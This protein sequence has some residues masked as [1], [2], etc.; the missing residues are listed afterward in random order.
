MKELLLI[1]LKNHDELD[2]DDMRFL[3]ETGDQDLRNAL[4]ES[5][6]RMKKKHVGVSV[7]F[8]GIIEFSNQC[9]RDCS[10]CGIR[11][12]NEDIKRFRIPMDEIVE[13][14]VWAHESDY[15]SILLQ[16]GERRD[17]DSINFVETALKNIW[18]ATNGALRVTLSLGDQTEETYRRWHEA[19]A[20]RY[21]LRIETSNADLFSKLHPDD[22]DHAQRKQSLVFLRNT[23]YQVGTGVMIGLPGQTTDDLIDD[24]CFFRKMDI[25][26]IGM[27]PYLV[28][29]DTP[30]AAEVFDYHPEHQLELGLRM[31]ALTRLFLKDV[32]IAATT[33]L[34][35]LAHDG[36]EQGIMAGAN[37][38]MPN[39][40]DVRYREGYQLYDGKPCM[41]ENATQCRGCL[42]DRVNSTGENIAFGEWGDAPHYV[43]RTQAVGV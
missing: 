15:A 5:A 35:A 19:G 10:Y 34:Q 37:V 11:R 8:R 3:L 32:N 27:G 17:S 20:A 14:A 36:R 2:R 33:A 43:K 24:I 13:A 31:I 40:T 30:L 21:L 1:K 42:T 29:S 28:H 4:M 41:D 7:Y 9:S 18:Q 12:S 25:D 38:I 26:M 39:L 22:P 23:G 16:S 6:Y